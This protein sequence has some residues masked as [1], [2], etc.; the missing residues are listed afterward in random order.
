MNKLGIYLDTSVIN[1]LFADDAP[2]KRDITI[3]YFENYVMN[4]VYE[5][6][7]SDIVISEIDR[8]KQKE[9]REKLLHVIDHFSLLIVP[10]EPLEEIEELAEHYI[11]SGVIPERKIDDAL[12]VAIC[13]VQ[14]ID[15]LLS[16]NFRHLANINKER[17]IMVSNIEAG[18]SFSPRLMNPMEVFNE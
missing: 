16:W 2:E 15:I 17:K 7:I 5:H 4:R 18:Y 12:H 8:T 3:E 10:S 1:F 9:L 6:C 11:K 14:K 13:T